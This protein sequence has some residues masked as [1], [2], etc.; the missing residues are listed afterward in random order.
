MGVVPPLHFVVPVWGEGF[1][2]TFLDYCLPAQLSPENIPVL[3]RGNHHTY[4]IHTARANYDSIMASPALQELQRAITVKIEFIDPVAPAQ[5]TT[6]DAKYRVKSGC[7]RRALQDAGARGAAAVLLNADIV[8]ANG[9]V[10]TAL[11]LLASG[12]RVIEVPAPRGLRDSI[13]PIL[14]SRYREPHGASISIEPDEL[15]ALWV[16]HIHPLLRM[17]FVEGPKGEPFHPSHLYWKVG[18]EGVVARCFHLYP[19]VVYQKG[20]S[21]DFSTTIDDDLVARLGFPDEEVF[22]AQDSREIFCCELSPPEQY[23]GHM[24]RRG[25]LR[26][27]AA[28]YLSYCGH[29]LRKLQRE[30][31][32]S[33]SHDL[34]PLWEARR[35]QS[36]VFTQRLLRKCERERNIIAL[37]KLIPPPA[38]AVLRCARAVFT[39][40][41]FGK[42]ERES[43]IALKKLIPPSAKAMLRR[44]R[45]VLIGN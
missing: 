42:C 43:I 19:I 6:A 15:S 40:R 32:I 20:A 27:Y 12:K 28:F 23:V 26:S 35:Q 8:L 38:K 36:A 11:D 29:N 24:A 2:K 34:G 25:D 10:R 7:Y 5:G 21:V 44:A 14:I 31:I 9:F 16:R 1:I 41:L 4:S 30:L 13:G 37:K 33:G 17:H 18:D 45:S 3:G 39:R 22:V